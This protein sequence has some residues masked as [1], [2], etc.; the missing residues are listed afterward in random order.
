MS[1]DP[2]VRVSLQEALA[3]ILIQ[4]A[5]V[6]EVHDSE[7]FL[8]LVAAAAS[9]R[10]EAD[11][12]LHTT[13]GSARAAG[14]T[15]QSIGSTL[16]MTKQAAQKR[17]AVRV[18]DRAA[19]DPNERTI[20]PTTTFEE[21][22]ELALAGQYGWHSVEFGATHHRV[23]RSHTQWEHLRVTMSPG[24]VS[25]LVADGWQ[26]IGSSFPY[27]YLKRDTGVPALNEMPGPRR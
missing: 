10:A 8:S 21:M 14:A 7:D 9:V 26:L 2:A 11:Q 24:R 12:L 25:K 19:L 20:G 5:E 22:Q 1:P 23:I 17:F 6:D 18:S 13:V 3:G 4:N 16:G 27:T 15:W